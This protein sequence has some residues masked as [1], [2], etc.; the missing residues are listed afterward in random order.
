M[1]PLPTSL[2][3]LTA[4]L[5]ISLG[6]ASSEQGIDEAKPHIG[7]EDGRSADFNGPVDATRVKR[8]V[9][10]YSKQCN[11][12]YGRHVC[13]RVYESEISV[14]PEDFTCWKVGTSHGYRKNCTETENLRYLADRG[15]YPDR[16]EVY[17]EPTRRP[18]SQYDRDDNRIYA[19]ADRIVV[20]RPRDAEFGA[21]ERRVVAHDAGLP[22]VYST[23]GRHGRSYDVRPERYA[24][25]HRHYERR[26]ERYESGHRHYERRPERYESGHVHYERRPER[27]ES[28]RRSGQQVYYERPE[29]YSPNA[30]PPYQHHH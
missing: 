24:P 25:G 8:Y 20:S 9:S 14:A 26:P 11:S 1:R 10:D 5:G 12:Y 17:G 7:T 27:Y 22:E 19:T 18:F 6:I 28:G 21:V 30:H 3:C 23:A 2:P 16:Y 4:L 15:F 29:R 13:Y